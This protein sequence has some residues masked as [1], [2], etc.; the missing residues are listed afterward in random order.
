MILWK[1]CRFVVTENL[2]NHLMN[3]IQFTHKFSTFGKVAACCFGYTGHHPIWIRWLYFRETNSFEYPHCYQVGLFANWK[4]PS[5]Y[6]KCSRSKILPEMLILV[7]D[8][9][10][11]MSFSVVSMCKKWIQ[12]SK[13]C[14]VIDWPCKTFNLKYL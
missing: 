13:W 5:W 11:S 4:S 7:S 10:V 12:L 2:C 1:F 8:L 3:S 9:K 14:F 6:Q